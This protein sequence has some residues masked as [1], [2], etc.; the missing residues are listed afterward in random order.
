ME[1]LIVAIIYAFITLF[2][3]HNLWLKTNRKR[4]QQEV[5]REFNQWVNEV[6]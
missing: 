4:N 3:A 5:E 6:K 1:Y 2:V